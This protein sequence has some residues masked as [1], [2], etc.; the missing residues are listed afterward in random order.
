MANE[1]LGFGLALDLGIDEICG[2]VSSAEEIEIREA[3]WYQQE[4][5]NKPIMPTKYVGQMLLDKIGNYTRK[6]KSG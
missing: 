2:S 3:S 1:S 6:N 4:I 5:K